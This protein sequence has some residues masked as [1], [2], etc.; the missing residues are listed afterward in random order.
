MGLIS[1]SKNIK[2]KLKLGKIIFHYGSY[3]IY[4][5][6]LGSRCK[7]SFIKNVFLHSGSIGDEEN[8]NKILLTFSAPFYLRTL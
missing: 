5:V 6:I 1:I 8:D 2:I 4:K 7:Q 3:V